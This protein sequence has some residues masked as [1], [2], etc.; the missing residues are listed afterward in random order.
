MGMGKNWDVEKAPAQHWPPHAHCP[1]EFESSKL[2]KLGQLGWWTG[3]QKKKKKK[4]MPLPL[5]PSTTVNKWVDLKPIFFIYFGEVSIPLKSPNFTLVCL[6]KKIQLPQFFPNHQIGSFFAFLI[7]QSFKQF[8]TSLNFIH[9]IKSMI[10][11]NYPKKFTRF[12]V[13]FLNKL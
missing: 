13:F 7:L 9:S 2:P 6:L 12:L 8:G 4:K 5:P 3:P 10:Q 11:K 1:L